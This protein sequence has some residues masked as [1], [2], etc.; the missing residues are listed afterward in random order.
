MISFEFD[1]YGEPQTLIKK[2]EDAKSPLDVNHKKKNK[3]IIKKIK[4]IKK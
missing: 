3:K 4:F 1:Y 2:E